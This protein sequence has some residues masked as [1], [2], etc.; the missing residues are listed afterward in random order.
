MTFLHADAANHGSFNENT[1][2]VRLELGST[3]I[4]LMG[5]AEAGGRNSPAIPPSPSSIE[6]VLLACCQQAVAADILIAARHGSRT[7][8]R[9]L[10]LDAV[11]ASVY[12]VSSG[13]MKYQTVVLPD[14]D[15]IA[16]LTPRGR[17]FRTDLN[18]ATCGQN[19]QKIG[20]DADGKP[21]GCDNVRLTIS[22]TGTV[23]AAYWPGSP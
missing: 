23:N 1:L 5:D 11:M 22:S 13:P 10:F 2:V 18:D 16:E 8:S 9:K 19:A 15:I 17:L 20:P 12:V 7:S 6:G 14:A 4:L 21:G 3:R